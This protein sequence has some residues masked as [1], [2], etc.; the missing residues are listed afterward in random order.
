MH[1]EHTEQ[2]VRPGLRDRMRAWGIKH[3]TGPH[4][5]TWLM[6]MAFA[7]ASFFPIPPDVLLI[8][9]LVGNKGKRWA[10]YALITTVFSVIG[11]I[12]GYLI[13]WFL[14]DTVGVFLFHAM[15]LDKYVAA[16][17]TGFQA[18]AFLAIFTAAFT[19]IPYKVF[20]IAA[21]LFKIN[22]WSLIVGSIIGRGLRFFIVAWLS[23][24]YGDY[25]GDIVY[26]YFNIASLLIVVVLI[27]VA[28]YL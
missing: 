17:Q 5:T 24:R 18:H 11:G 15:R 27:L 10:Y 20:T 6:L 7:E 12:G 26:K 8:A 23:K 4:A 2:P 1:E 21:G 3:A 9:I 14:Y 16:V 28:F 22:L 19:P 25:I 13:G